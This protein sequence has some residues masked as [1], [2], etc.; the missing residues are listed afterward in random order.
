MSWLK[1][2]S[3]LFAIRMDPRPKSWLRLLRLLLI[4]QCRVLLDCEGYYG[5]EK[6]ASGQRNS[7]ENE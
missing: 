3:M 7:G 1:R 5:A 2:K 6:A 4:L